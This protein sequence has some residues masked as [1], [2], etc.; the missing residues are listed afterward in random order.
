MGIYIP[1]MEMPK[2]GAV[3]LIVC[4]SGNV[5]TD[6]L[7]L[8]GEAV[9][10]PPHGRLGDLDALFKSFSY[11]ENLSVLETM[12][13]QSKISDALTIIPAEEET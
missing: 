4:S 5:Y 1:G 3:S 6:D 8:V 2:G 12:Y 13:V 10:V 9:P 7:I 11:D